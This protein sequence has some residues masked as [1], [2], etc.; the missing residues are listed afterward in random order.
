MRWT[1]HKN[2]TPVEARRP[3]LEIY[4][5]L[6]LR[7]EPNTTFSNV[8]FTGNCSS[9]SISATYYIICFISIELLSNE[10]EI[11]HSL[12][13]HRVKTRKEQDYAHLVRDEETPK[14]C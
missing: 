9:V 5:L 8:T 11:A 12:L 1:D 2:G 3:R 13:S 7:T 4:Y 14:I 6:T 10:F